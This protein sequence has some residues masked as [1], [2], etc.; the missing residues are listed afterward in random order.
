M[1]KLLSTTPIQAVEDR[2][3][4]W[5]KTITIFRYSHSGEIMPVEVPLNIYTERGEAD[6]VTGDT[7]N[8]NDPLIYPFIFIE[9]LPL[10]PTGRLRIGASVRHFYNFPFALAFYIDQ[11]PLDHDRIPRLNEELNTM[12][13]KLERVLQEV[14]LFG[15]I[16]PTE[17]TNPSVISEG[18][19]HKFISIEI[20][21][22]LIIPEEPKIETIDLDFSL[23]LD[24]IGGD[25]P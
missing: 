25:K 1:G 22:D 4:K 10:R 20:P 17:P 5:L 6:L 11:N 19:L 18:I 21:E 9:Q 15:G 3:R 12:D 7:H 2:L 8:P 23:N 24:I 14:E 13:L 16:W